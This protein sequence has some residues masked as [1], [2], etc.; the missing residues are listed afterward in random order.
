[1]AGSTHALHWAELLVI[2]LKGRTTIMVRWSAYAGEVTGSNPV[3]AIIF[4]LDILANPMLP[5]GGMGLVHLM[6]SRRPVNRQVTATSP[7]VRLVISML[8]RIRTTMCQLVIGPYYTD[9]MCHPLS[10]ATCHL[11]VGLY[12]CHVTLSILYGCHMSP[13]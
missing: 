8:D 4:V 12:T 1:M 9:A 13:C 10:G 11:L 6:S 2:T 5:R 3:E 7:S